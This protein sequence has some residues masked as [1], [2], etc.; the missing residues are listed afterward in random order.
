M[1]RFGAFHPLRR[2]IASAEPVLFAYVRDSPVQREAVQQ[3]ILDRIAAIQRFSETL[4]T[5]QLES[6]DARSHGGMLEVVAILSRD[7]RGLAEAFFHPGP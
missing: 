2:E 1:T 3:E 5:A 7:A 6:P 4:A